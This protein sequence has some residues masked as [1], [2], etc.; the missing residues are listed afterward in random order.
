MSWCRNSTEPAKSNAPVGIVRESRDGEQYQLFPHPVLWGHAPGSS[1]D[2]NFA[3]CSIAIFSNLPR[4][5][6]FKSRLKQP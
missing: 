5:A 3:L 2:A 4:L 1:G 6:Y